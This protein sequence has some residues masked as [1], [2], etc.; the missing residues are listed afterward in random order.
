MPGAE[1][2]DLW[3]QL[4]QI[5]GQSPEIAQQFDMPKIFKHIAYQMG[6]KDVEGFARQVQ[7]VPQQPQVMGDEQVAE[8]EA[9]GNV[10]PIQPNIMAAVM[11][12]GG[13]GKN[14]SNPSGISS[15]A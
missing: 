1:P 11:G 2:T 7:P 13:G 10:T 9:E 14:I 6:A 12:G 8:Q 5:M 15:F 3:V 4:F